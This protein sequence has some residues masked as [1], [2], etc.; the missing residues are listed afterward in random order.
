MKTKKKYL[1]FKNYLTFLDI[2]A[3]IRKLLIQIDLNSLITRNIAAL[4]F[5]VDHQTLLDLVHCI[6][7]LIFGALGIS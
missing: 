2:M 1:C 5:S 3:I 6:P 4:I 7:L